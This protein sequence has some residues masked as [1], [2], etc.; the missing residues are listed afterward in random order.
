V[1]LCLHSPIRF[2]GV[3]IQHRDNFALI[4]QKAL[5]T[6]QKQRTEK[7]KNQTIQQMFISR[8]VKR[9]GEITFMGR[10]GTDY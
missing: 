8:K 3:A 4:L 1:E 7:A 2:H 9:N 6:G 5:K 10:Q